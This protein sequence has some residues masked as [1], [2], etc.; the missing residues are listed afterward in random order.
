M[1]Y[2]LPTG[3][4]SVEDNTRTGKGQEK[5]RGKYKPVNYPEVA[6]SILYWSHIS[7]DME[8]REL[9]KKVYDYGL[10]NRRGK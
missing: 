8:M 10:N 3:E 7:G 2:I 4:I 1:E 9:A 6:I 5:W